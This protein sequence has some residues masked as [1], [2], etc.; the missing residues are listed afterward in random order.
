MSKGEDTQSNADVMQW[1]AFGSVVVFGLGMAYAIHMTNQVVKAVDENH[2]KKIIINSEKT[3][4]QQ[5]AQ[6]Q[7]Q[8]GEAG[9]GPNNTTD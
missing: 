4:I 9:E 5:S 6:G 3:N 1:I 7:D 2:N 8:Q